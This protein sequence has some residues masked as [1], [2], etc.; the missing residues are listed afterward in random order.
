MTLTSSDKR[1]VSGLMNDVAKLQRDVKLLASAKPGLAQ[2]SIENGSIDEYTVNGQLASVIGKQHDGT[3]TT[4]STTGPTPPTPWFPTA[5]TV[6][7]VIEIRWN[8]KFAGDAPSPMDFKHVAAYAVPVGNLA[9]LTDQSGV[10]TG[11]LGDT[12]QIQTDPGLYDIYLAAWTLS[13]KPSALA[14]PVSVVVPAPADGDALQQAIDDAQAAVDAA[15]A[16]LA[17]AKL[18]LD[19]RLDTAESELSDHDDRLIADAGRINDAFGQIAELETVQGRQVT[20]GS[21]PP[22]GVTPGKGLWVTPSGH[23]YISQECNA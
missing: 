11:E 18:E 17:A 15:A 13:G 2:S 1:A 21:S 7:G 16:E 9:N 12:V 19:G 5:K 14:G 22:S 8:G 4:T 6:P 23:T 3:H 20:Y 10:M